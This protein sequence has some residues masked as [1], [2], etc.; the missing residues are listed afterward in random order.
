MFVQYNRVP[1]SC[2]FSFVL[3]ANLQ[4]SI[5]F[6]LSQTYLVNYHTL[7]EGKKNAEGGDE[8]E[9]CE[10]MS[11]MMSSGGDEESKTGIMG[12]MSSS[13][14]F[15][16]RYA[17]GL[18]LK[19]SRDSMADMLANEEHTKDLGKKE[20]QLAQM[21]MAVETLHMAEFGV[22]EEE[23][24]SS[25]IYCEEHADE[26]IQD[27][28][29]SFQEK[30]DIARAK[31]RIHNLTYDST[32]VLEK[33]GEEVDTEVKLR[34][35]QQH[36][37]TMDAE[38]DALRALQGLPPETRDDMFIGTLIDDE[39]FAPAPPPPDCPI[40]FLPLPE[41]GHITYNPCCGKVSRM[42]AS[43]LG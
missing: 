24:H 15:A 34:L 41:R 25:L 22:L 35:M 39:L 11:N 19:K 14:R 13:E 18:E 9:L 38:V 23:K 1:E 43:G 30:M 3:H 29:K 28:G 16:E 10:M 21:L 4:L 5:S 36:V 26:L 20:F 42:I 17:K 12:D 32:I 6:L 8:K 31:G 7:T 2:Y 27:G 33:L 37:R 40:C